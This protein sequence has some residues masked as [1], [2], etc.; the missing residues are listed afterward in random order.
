MKRKTMFKTGDILELTYKNVTNPAN[1]LTTRVLILR[2][3]I[4]EYHEY[5]DRAMDVSYMLYIEPTYWTDTKE[6][7]MLTE[8]VL[9][10]EEELKEEVVK[11]IGHIDLSKW[12]NKK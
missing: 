6:L 4:H 5:E 10:N 7:Q 1:E 3:F 9:I 8:T 11:K 2:T 12:I